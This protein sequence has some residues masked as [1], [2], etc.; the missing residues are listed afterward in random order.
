MLWAMLWN[1]NGSLNVRELGVRTFR[2]IAV[3]GVC[4]AVGVLIS[5]LG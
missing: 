5:S 1:R 3:A 2:F 4:V